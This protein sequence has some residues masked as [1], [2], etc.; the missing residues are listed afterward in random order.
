MLRRVQVQ[1]DDVGG[2]RF[3][4]G[5]VAGQ[6]SLDPMWFQARLLPHPVHHIF[7]DAQMGREVAATPRYSWTEKV[8]VVS[9]E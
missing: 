1:T 4:I 3:E 2:F 5:I 6:V 8:Q 7:A 9:L